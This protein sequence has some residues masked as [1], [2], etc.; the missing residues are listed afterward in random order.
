MAS[1]QTDHSSVHLKIDHPQ[2]EHTEGAERTGS[3][4]QSNSYSL[5]QLHVTGLLYSLS[6]TT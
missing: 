3:E 1:S 4:A 6:Y 5:L 2:T